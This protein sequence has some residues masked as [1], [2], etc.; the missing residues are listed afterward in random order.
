MNTKLTLKSRLA[1][2]NVVWRNQQLKIC[3]QL[4]G[5]QVSGDLSGVLAVC[6]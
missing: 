5:I 1:Q 3:T 6:P 2:S 4:T